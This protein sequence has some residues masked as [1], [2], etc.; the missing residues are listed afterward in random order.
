MSM[1]G[2][3]SCFLTALIILSLVGFSSSGQNGA[4]PD[5]FTTSAQTIPTSVVAKLIPPQPYSVYVGQTYVLTV[6]VQYSVVPSD[7]TVFLQITCESYT[8]Q[9]VPVSGSGTT[10]ISLQLHAPQSPGIYSLQLSLLVRIP[11]QPASVWD[12]AAVNYQVVQPVITDWD[13]QRAWVVP[14]SPGVGD[15]VTFHATIELKSTTSTEPLNVIVAVLLDKS[16]YYSGSM[17]FQPQPSTQ[18]FDVPKAWMASKGTHVLT[19]VVD[20][21]GRH[22]D[23]TPYPYSNFKQVQFAVGE[24]YAIITNISAP[25]EV[26]QGE[27]FN[28]VVAVEYKLPPSANLKLDHFSYY[29]NMSQPAHNQTTDTVSGSGSKDYTFPVKAPVM[30][31]CSALQIS[32]NETVMFDIGKGWQTSGNASWGHYSVNLKSPEYY[33]KITSLEATYQPSPNQTIPI[34]IRVQVEYY[35]PNMAAL[36]ITVSRSVASGNRTQVFASDNRTQVTIW[37]DE[38]NITQPGKPT[39]VSSPVEFVYNFVCSDCSGNS[40][41]L[42][43]HATVDYVACDG[44]QSG[45]EASTQITVPNPQRTAK[46][47]LDY[48]FAALQTIMNWF[49]KLFGLG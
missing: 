38:E 16:L 2:S 18:N 6:G 47:P 31:M 36:R 29:G 35:L 46:T 7:E 17:T 19:V 21:Q 37:K 40:T 39:R 27:W 49:R 30:G 24:Y 48:F 13:V 41:T 25:Q 23:P 12:T 43:F 44:W 10:A 3:R 15:N 1:V 28:V 34:H 26:G 45:G 11:G 22:N 4:A 14:G 20:P 5:V 42:T 33:A 32:G 8:S 9:F